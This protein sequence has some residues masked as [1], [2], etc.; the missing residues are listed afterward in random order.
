MVIS[1]NI[2]QDVS[3]LSSITLKKSISVCRLKG[4]DDT[5]GRRRQKHQGLTVIRTLSDFT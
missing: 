5:R 1:Q 3:L 2:P 4:E